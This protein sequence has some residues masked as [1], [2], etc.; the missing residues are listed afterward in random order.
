MRFRP[1][2]AVLLVMVL[3]LS[4]CWSRRELTDVSFA[5]LVGIDWV[6]DQY[7]I[8]VNIN[9]PQRSA[10]EQA[11]SNTR[12]VFTVSERAPSPDAALAK[13]DQILERSLTLSHVRSVVFGETM[14]RRGIGPVLDFLLRSVEIRPTAWMAVTN[15]PA[16]ELLMAR[17]L[18]DAP[19]EGPLGYHDAASRRS[20]ISPARRLTDAAN[21]LQEEGVDL[22]L[23][24]FRRADR[25]APESGKA[26]DQGALHA[27]E[28]HP[29]EIVY[30]GAGVFVQD[31]LV[32]WLTPEQA[33]GQLWANDRVAHGAISSECPEP[34][35]D[36]RV[37]FRL[38]R[39][40]GKTKTHL[41]GN[42]VRG[43]V[44]IKVAVDVNDVTCSGPMVRDG[45]V[46]QL[47]QVLADRV[48]E[49][50]ERALVVSRET[51]SDFFGFGQELFRDAPG[52]YLSREKKWEEILRTMPVTITVDASV[53]RLGQ[54]NL[55]YRWRSPR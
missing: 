22:T 28:D 37:V 53:V 24:L 49:N 5:A 43:S 36:E 9:Q 14:A 20:S 48:R 41:E 12:R 31:K 55:K 27:K 29:A 52:A 51:G 17:P 3:L 46:S 44:N 54:V 18:Q 13:L 7:Q 6:D 1:L 33:R 47:E 34:K 15:G 39:G 26:E 16:E 19:A 11:E 23:P 50:I 35:A 42:K 8:T 25:E 38:R 4:G 40:S 2:V 10:G 30:G 32:G 21:I 45:D